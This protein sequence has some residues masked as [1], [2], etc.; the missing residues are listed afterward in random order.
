[1]IRR[2]VEEQRLALAAELAAARSDIANLKERLEKWEG[3]G[4]P[5]YDHD[6]LTVWHKV[7]GFMNDPRFMSA[8][9]RGMDSGHIIAR[10][11]DVARDIHIEWRIHVCCWA[12]WHASRLPGDFVECGT[13][14]GIMSLAV[15]EYV[16]FNE[17][18]KDFWL[19]DTYA[20]I[21]EDMVSESEMELGRLAENR[22]YP[23]CYEKALRNFSPFPRAHLVRGRVPET[24]STVS[25]ADVS[26]LCIDMNIEQPERE[27]L[28][29]FWPK[30]VSG[31]VVVFDD[32]AWTPYQAQKRSHDTFASR[33]GVEILTLPTGQGLL[34][35][36]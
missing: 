14:T 5:I 9:Q 12:A 22:M 1:M 24:L 34:I 20:G 6:Y 21:P 10:Q 25:I 29:Y 2:P 3:R 31:A 33:Q 8:Y 17:V 23:D 16:N 7:L 27:A 18:D 11:D 15:C 13:N 26:Y 28:E 32:Y 4:V 35:K 19:F 36:S 30:L